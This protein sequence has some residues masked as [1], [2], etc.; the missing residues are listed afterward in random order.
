MQVFYSKR[1]HERA[2]YHVCLL[3]EYLWKK[4]AVLWLVITGYSVR[5]AVTVV[6][7]CNGEMDAC[8]E[9][10]DSQFIDI[11]NTID[12]KVRING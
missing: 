1:L 10:K 12:S 5:I 7:L 3:Q 2:D 9:I 4:S 6:Y 8:Y 11:P